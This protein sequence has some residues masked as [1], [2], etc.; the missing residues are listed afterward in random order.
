MSTSKN[1]EWERVVDEE[2]GVLIYRLDGVMGDTDGAF[3]LHD[4]LREDLEATGEGVMMRVVLDMGNI[5]FLSSTGI[6]I[7]ASCHTTAAAAGKVFVLSA[8]PRQAARV[9]DITGVGGIVPRYETEAD[10]IDPDASPVK[11]SY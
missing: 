2:K 3:R 11:G 7:V 4:V 10:A 6:G 9:L 8:V 1:L 5:E